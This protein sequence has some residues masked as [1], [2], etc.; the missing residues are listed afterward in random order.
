MVDTLD[1]FA[2]AEKQEEHLAKI[3]E[4]ARLEMFDLDLFFENAYFMG[5]LDPVIG[6]H[7]TRCTTALA[8]I[9]SENSV[10]VRGESGTGKTKIMN[11]C[12]DLMWGDEAH[13]GEVLEVYPIYQSAEKG[14][15]TWDEA[16]R[17]RQATWCFIPELQNVK[18][19]IQMIKGW[20]EGKTWVYKRQNRKHT[21]TETIELVPLPILTNLAEG[22]EVM[23]DIG[24]EMRRR[25]LN[26]WTTNSMAQNERIKLRKAQMRLLPEK[27]LLTM[28][29][30]RKQLLRAHMYNVIEKKPE[31]IVNPCIMEISKAIPSKFVVSNSYTDYFFNAIESVAKFYY[32]RN[33]WIDDRLIASPAD[34]KIAW[35][36]FGPQ[37]VDAC[38]G[39]PFGIGRSI[40][41]IVPEIKTFE[42]LQA[43]S[44]GGFDIQDIADSLE[45]DGMAMEM[46]A[47]NSIMAKL[48][49]SGSVKQNPRT[50]R[51]SKRKDVGH[52][53]AGVNWS[54]MV[55]EAVNFM[56]MTYPD[57][58]GQYETDYCTG[59]GLVYV[60]PFTGV[61]MSLLTDK[62]VREDAED[63][64]LNLLNEKFELLTLSTIELCVDYFKNKSTP[65]G[66][67][68]KVF[69]MN[70][71]PKQV[72]LVDLDELSDLYELLK[73]SD[74]G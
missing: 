46:E 37:L 62:K 6:N 64:R 20:T 24:A 61:T 28:N 66:P 4:V 45:V 54:K 34:N 51:Y 52:D 22:N 43:D 14:L 5:K 72:G 44:S 53:D 74:N 42:G 13:L 12:M 47:L 60:H 36:I 11:A 8:W 69:F 65:M 41:D 33:M 19:H 7:E 2:A 23:K 58:A 57:H 59:K 39:I 67:P 55:D 63:E 70:D 18:A 56:R 1:I 29:M 49:A 38:L 31:V 3:A 30:E 26:V 48:T 16:E 21:S 68:P 25:F 10:I 71:I 35:I 15:L 27:E 9:V 73:R 40:V 50:K 17:I 32:N